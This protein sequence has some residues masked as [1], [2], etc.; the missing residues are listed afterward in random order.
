MHHKD[1]ISGKVILVQQ[2]IVLGRCFPV[3]DISFCS[4]QLTL[5]VYENDNFQV[6]LDVGCGTGVLSIFCAFAGATRVSFQLLVAH[7]C[8]C[9]DLINVGKLMFFNPSLYRCYYIP[10]IFCCC[11][12]TIHPH[13]PHLPKNHYLWELILSR[14]TLI[15]MLNPY[16]I[17][18]FFTVYLKNT[19]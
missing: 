11:S 18:W 10:H 16:S 9:D 2:C 17:I 3:Y 4:A 15:N 19:C 7:L 12:C 5:V 6:V 8:I 13:K 14:Q 1:L